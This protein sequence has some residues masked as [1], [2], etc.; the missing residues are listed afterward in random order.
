MNIESIKKL[1]QTINNGY[2][3]TSEYN[4]FEPSSYYVTLYDLVLQHLI[5]SN[6]KDIIKQLKKTQLKEG[7]IN[8]K[9]SRSPNNNHSDLYL[10]LHSSSIFYQ[11][12][13]TYIP[14]YPPIEYFSNFSKLELNHFLNAFDYSDAWRVSNEIMGL[15]VLIAF[16]EK[17]EQNIG[18]L[19]I[20]LDEIKSRQDSKSGLWHGTKNKSIINGI[21]A[22]FHYVPLYDYLNEKL[23]FK[24][25]ILSSILSIA[26]KNGYFSSPAGY[27]C[28]DYD[29]VAILKYLVVNDNGSSISEKSKDQIIKTIKKLYQSIIDSQNSDGGFGEYGPKKNLLFDTGQL[30][31]SFFVHRSVSTFSWNF[32]KI[33]RLYFFKNKLLYSNSVQSCVSLPFE[34]NTFA[35]WFKVMTLSLCEE[36]LVTYQIL[37][38]PTIKIEKFSLPGLGRL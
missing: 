9:Q 12:I 38:K 25:E 15:A 1:R 3:K 6:E 30:I 19:Q 34:S 16:N 24:E 11:L 26:L 10:S 7:L 4:S 13:D 36:I 21:A 28:I 33:I 37:E 2:S 31:K 20:I 32:K 35:T 27:A 5:Y 23:D 17:K 18:H 22:T 29:C 14:D 8:E